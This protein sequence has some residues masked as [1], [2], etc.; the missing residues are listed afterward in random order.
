ML[1]VLIVALVSGSVAGFIAALF[2]I[3]PLVGAVLCAV[4][5]Y[6]GIACYLRRS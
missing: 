1:L 5:V 4:F 3:A 2:T 6:L